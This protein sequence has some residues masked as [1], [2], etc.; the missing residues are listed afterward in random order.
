MTPSTATEPE[1][2]YLGDLQRL[3]LKPGDRLVLTYAGHLSEANA[4]L[5][6][7]QLERWAPPD[8]QVLVLAGDVKIGVIGA[9]D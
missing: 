2:R 7:V 9:A 5:L 4:E 1:I 6:K 3:Q 8:V